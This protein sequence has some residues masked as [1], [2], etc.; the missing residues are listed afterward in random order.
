MFSKGDQLKMKLSNLKFPEN[1]NL[2]LFLLIWGLEIGRGDC[3]GNRWTIESVRL[4]VLLGCN[5]WCLFF[6]NR[7]ATKWRGSRIISLI[8]FQNAPKTSCQRSKSNS[9]ISRAPPWEN[10]FRHLFWGFKIFLKGACSLI[11]VLWV[12]DTRYLYLI[13][14]LC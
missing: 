11:H 9:L 7:K 8:W 4:W 10:H 12:S 3:M 13:H 2:D 1:Y 5:L 14:V 6:D